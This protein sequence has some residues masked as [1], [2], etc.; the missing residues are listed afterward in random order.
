M[1]AGQTKF[2]IGSGLII[3]AVFYLAYLVMSKSKDEHG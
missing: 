1:C 2:V 3:F